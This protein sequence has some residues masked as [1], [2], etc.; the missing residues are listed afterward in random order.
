MNFIVLNLLSVS[1]RNGS[2]AGGTEI[3]LA[4]SLDQMFAREGVTR[5]TIWRCSR[6]VL[7]SPAQSLMHRRTG[8]GE[9]YHLRG[10]TAAGAAARLP[11]HGRDGGRGC[12]EAGPK[13]LRDPERQFLM[14][15]HGMRIVHLIPSSC[16]P[17]IEALATRSRDEPTAPMAQHHTMTNHPRAI[18]VAKCYYAP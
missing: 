15:D 13:V 4:F 17:T 8:R 14:S 18:A 5:L 1:V 7:G 9:A 2:G 12:D 16:C 6:V 10:C 11:G 3:Q